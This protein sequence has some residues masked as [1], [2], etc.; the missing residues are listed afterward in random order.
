MTLTTGWRPSTK[1][2]VVAEFLTT[3]HTA[4][5]TTI[6]AVPVDGSAPARLVT[7]SGSGGTPAVRSDGGAVAAALGGGVAVWELSGVV[8]WIVPNDGGITA[9]SNPVWSPD[10]AYVYF[11]RYKPAVTGFGE[12][13][14]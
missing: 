9:T 14:G 7:V 3:G 5:G 10:G 2:V 12:D 8:R 13:L 11:G 1:T 6:V 4:S